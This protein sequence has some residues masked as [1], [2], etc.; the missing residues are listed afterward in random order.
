MAVKYSFNPR[1]TNWDLGLMA[2]RLSCLFLNERESSDVIL[3][4]VCTSVMV[5]KGKKPQN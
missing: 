1:I 5:P 4:E 3:L 2:V